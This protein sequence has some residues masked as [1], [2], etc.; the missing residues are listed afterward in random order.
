MNL[1]ASGYGSQSVAAGVAHTC[2]ISTTG[3]QCWGIGTNGQLGNGT[4]TGSMSPVS[5]S[6][7]GPTA[8][9]VGGS[10]TCD[11]LPSGVVHCW[12]LNANGP[13]C[14]GTTT[15]RFIPATLS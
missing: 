11:M 6:L 2:A 3:V 13:I 8:I 7:S 10:H 9:A 15:M 5:V 14:D 1:L 12:G 4:T